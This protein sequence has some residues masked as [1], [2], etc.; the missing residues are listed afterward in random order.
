MHL[1]CGLIPSSLCCI[2]VLP[3][4][5]LPAFASLTLEWRSHNALYGTIPELA[6]A[7]FSLASYVRQRTSSCC[8]G[9]LHRD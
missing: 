7:G 4:L 2:A 9:L 8:N 1:I 5:L 6:G 3:V